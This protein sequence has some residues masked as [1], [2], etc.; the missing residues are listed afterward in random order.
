M[1]VLRRVAIGF[2]VAVALVVVAGV[3]GVLVI[4]G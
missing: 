3:A 4:G 2:G 1:R